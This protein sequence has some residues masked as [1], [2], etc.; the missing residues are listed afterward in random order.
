[1]SVPPDLKIGFAKWRKAKGTPDGGSRSDE[2]I[3]RSVLAKFHVPRKVVEP[4]P[5]VP[6]PEQQLF[7]HTGK[8]VRQLH[9]VS[10]ECP[11][12][13]QKPKCAL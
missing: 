1:M 11:L 5:Y 12:P 7:E 10:V 4:S 13:S 6:P 9:Q 3:I 2:N 8:S